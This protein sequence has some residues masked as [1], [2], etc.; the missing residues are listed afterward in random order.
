M[1][2]PRQLLNH[3]LAEGTADRP[4]VDLGSSSVTGLRGV[5]GSGD[6]PSGGPGGGIVGHPVLQTQVL[7]GPTSAGLGS[8]SARAGCVFERPVLDE[9]DTFLDLIGVRWRCTDGPPAE[10][11]HPLEH[12]TQAQIA[13]YPRPQW[14]TALQVADDFTIEHQQLVVA[15]PPCP[16][17][18][19]MCFA[20][21]NGWQFLDD[22]TG[23]WRVANALLDW[24]LETVVSAYEHLLTR[25]PQVPD[26]VI[27]RDDYG[28]Q[29]SMYVSELDFRTFIR[30][31]LRTIM[32]WI[33]R[34]TPAR[35]VFHSCG[36]I[37]PIVPDLVTLGVDALNLQPDARGIDLIKLR[38][39]LPGTL[40]LH[41]V[42]DLPALGQAIESGD[43]SALLQ[44]ARLFARLWPAMAAPLD[45]LAADVSVSSLVRAATFLKTLTLDDLADLQT[46]RATPHSLQ[47][48]LA[49]A[50]EVSLPPVP[51]S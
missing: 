3:L 35:I 36:A 28:V 48:A 43:M 51:T 42:T 8:D 2:T 18:I 21:R 47:L 16:G 39:A 9:D 32:S 22:L 10:F 33:R 15:E 4:L 24:C 38:Q 40:A 30:P 44:Q 37:A 31:R 5:A 46:G 25:L 7:D 1:A 13:G 20:L 45:V 12:A 49:A 34:L 50:Q 11:E 19:E 14:P 6:I 26:V 41:G 17:L 29:G 27:Y 23:G